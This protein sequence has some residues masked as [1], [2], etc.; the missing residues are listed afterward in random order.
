[1]A[2]EFFNP[3]KPKMTRELINLTETKMPNVST[4]PNQKWL[5][6]IIDPRGPKWGR[7][8][9][10]PARLGHKTVTTGNRCCEP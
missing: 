2:G 5:A 8:E 1:M 9:H 10:R 4:S 7:Q 6:R 3:V